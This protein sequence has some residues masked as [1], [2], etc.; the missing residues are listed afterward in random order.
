MLHYEPRTEARLGGLILGSRE[1]VLHALPQEA[2]P[3]FR[4]DDIVHDLLDG[5]ED[6]DSMGVKLNLPPGWAL[7]YYQCE[8]GPTTMFEYGSICKD[9][10]RLHHVRG[11]PPGK[12]EYSFPLE[13]VGR[14]VRASAG[15][16]PGDVYW[17]SPATRAGA[18]NLIYR[19][20]ICTRII[21]FD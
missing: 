11:L 5:G 20:A 9:T 18:T 3:V 16:R 1:S 15:L 14:H 19:A 13:I 12:E 21:E 10:V 4:T 7:M 17:W 2:R 6:V 8:D